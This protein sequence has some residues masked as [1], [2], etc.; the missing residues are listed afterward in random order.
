MDTA[1][2]PAGPTTF[3]DLHRPG[4]PLVLPNAWD[5]GSARAFVAAGFA[6]VGTTSLGVAASHGLV[7]GTGSDRD[8]TV[9]LASDLVAAHLGCPVTVDLA[10]GYSTDPGRV[11][12]LVAGLGVAGVNLEDS[13]AGV[14]VD[15]AV[16]AARLLAVRDRAPGVF[17]NART[18]VLWLGGTD[19]DEAVD[20][21][22]RYADAGADGVFLPG[23]TDPAAI[24][25]DVAAVDRPLNVLATPALPLSRLAA[26]G[27]ARV[28]TGSLPYR[29]ALRAAVLAATATRDGLALPE[30]VGYVQVQALH[31]G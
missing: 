25:R 10:D 13:T 18:D 27:V 3:A 24:E 28:S 6:A 8:H 9:A 21:L 22:R 16:H 14:L 30:A 4:D 11:A 12:E 26:L 20:R 15:P 29:A 19:L 23:A 17:V 1:P 31:G 2:T 7:D 5:V